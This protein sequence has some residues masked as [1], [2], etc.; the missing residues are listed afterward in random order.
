LVS[1]NLSNGTTENRGTMLKDMNILHI[2]IIL[3]VH[4]Y[5][6]VFDLITVK[7]WIR[8]NAQQYMLIVYMAWNW[9]GK[10]KDNLIYSFYSLSY[11]D[12]NI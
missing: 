5:K 4:W 6:N 8:Y 2:D 1:S 10:K 12:H 11:M 3:T 9:N 7:R